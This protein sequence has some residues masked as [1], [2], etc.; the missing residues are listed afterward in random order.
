MDLS[1]LARTPEEKWLEIRG[2]LK[3]IRN[4]CVAVTLSSPANKLLELSTN[5]RSLQVFLQDYNG[6]TDLITYLNNTFQG[7][8]G[9]P[10]DYD[11][12]AEFT[13]LWQAINST[14]AAI[15]A[16]SY[17]SVV[18][19]NGDGVMQWATI[20]NSTVITAITAITNILSV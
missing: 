13:S 16:L 11:I 6:D 19:L 2:R 17:T 5:L 12:S 7:K 14:K 10:V 20:D 9:R 3:N 4:E 15:A 8:N 1:E 18:S